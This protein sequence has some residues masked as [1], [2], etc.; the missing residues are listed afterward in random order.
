MPD[1]AT[2]PPD[3][4]TIHFWCALAFTACFFVPMVRLYGSLCSARKIPQVLAAHDQLHWSHVSFM[5]YALPVLGVLAA[6]LGRAARPDAWRL[7]STVL[8]MAGISPFVAVVVSLCL[9]LGIARLWNMLNA[10]AWLTIVGGILLLIFAG[11]E[12][13]Y[14]HSA[15]VTVRARGWPSRGRN[16]KSGRCPT[17][18]RV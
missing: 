13:T 12:Y 18:A 14:R 16:I 17:R 7:K 8:T 9:H 5:L 6:L 10:G 3:L 15:K 4:G 1:P 2:S 11:V